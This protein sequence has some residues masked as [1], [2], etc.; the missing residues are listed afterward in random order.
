MKRPASMNKV[1]PRSFGEK[2]F[3]ANRRRI[4]IKQTDRGQQGRGWVNETTTRGRG[5]M[6]VK[7]KVIMER[8]KTL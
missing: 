1:I 7:V 4:C 8:R 3:S 2:C 5:D 6:K